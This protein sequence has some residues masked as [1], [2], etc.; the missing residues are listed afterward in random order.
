MY[1]LWLCVTGCVFDLYASLFVHNVC[2][3]CTFQ[4]NQQ[5]NL[6]YALISVVHYKDEA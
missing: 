6:M 1:F 3:Y 5:I 2:M 4:I